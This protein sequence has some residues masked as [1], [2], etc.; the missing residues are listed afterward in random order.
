M[1]DFYHVGPTASPLVICGEAGN[2]TERDLQLFL[3]SW[4][5]VAEQ[6]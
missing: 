6:A 1:Q 2:R 4:L 3:V 5:W